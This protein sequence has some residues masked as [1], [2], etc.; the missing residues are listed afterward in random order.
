MPGSATVRNPT[1]P[2]S[3]HILA[4]QPELA[5][6]ARSFSQ[7]APRLAWF[8]GAGASAQS[9]VPTAEQLVD[10]LL[11][12]I[13][14]TERGVPV[15]SIDLGDRHQRRRL[16]E[17]YSGQ[18]GLSLDGDPSF[19][20]EVFERAYASP[21]DRAAFIESQVRE[22]APNYGHQVLAALVAAN[23]L[24]LVAT[25]NFDPLIERAINPLLDG[26]LLDGRQLDVADL[27]NPGRVARALS[28][29]RWPLL[30]KLHGDYRS[31]DLKNI[32]TELQEQDEE[33]R[34]TMTSALSRLGLVVV[35]YSGRDES[36]INMLQDVLALPTPFP[37]GLV[38]VKRPQDALLPSVADLLSNAQAAG[39][40]TSIVTASS[41]VDLTTRIQQAMTLPTPVRQWLSAR[42][43]TLTR[44]AETAVKGP[45]GT[46]P[47]LQLN[48]L[49]VEQLPSKAR[50][51][52]W[53]AN[54]VSIDSLREALRGPERNALVGLVSGTAAAF[55][56]D[57]TLRAALVGA[58]VRVT[59]AYE[60]LDLGAD[61]SGEVDTQALGLVTDA[62]VVG[63]AR[64]RGL[65]PVL[66]RHRPHLLRVIRPNDPA[67]QPLNRACGGPLR[68]EIHH[69]ASGLRLPWA[70]AVS[71]NL[72][73]RHG[74]WWLLLNPEIWTRRE[75]LPGDGGAP[76]SHA[77]LGALLD[78]RKEFIRER[79]AKRYN[80]QTGEILTAWM[81]ILTG[82]QRAE[83]RTF[84]LQGGAGIDAGF[85][86][87]GRAATSLPL[88]SRNGSR[89]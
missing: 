78:Q 57:S 79:N 13:Y 1:N 29:D 59:D 46:G 80:R 54:P 68:G 34:R 36:I 86:L 6:F 41:F 75:P 62:L 2:D 19:Y 40:E 58:G 3:D 74:Q 32:S 51:L 72:E 82:G 21:Q 42:A 26:Q 52:E 85:V 39:V 53:A 81:E 55:G 11:R 25:T 66:R 20:S 31:D 88:L 56:Q 28:A 89:D 37:A 44:R 18:E 73:R 71:A 67:L 77:E 23:S 87:D 22:A 69:R 12:Q 15:D 43:P 9:F 60:S 16:H 48:A 8:L 64:L 47:I 38:W 24:R 49:P 76:P 65:R 27:D 17:I 35:G 50:R 7:R 30:V 70:E 84:G 45:T 10:V 4:G 63:L 83:I 5:A 14:C 61:D 33:L